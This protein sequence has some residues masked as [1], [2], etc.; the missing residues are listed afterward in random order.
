MFLKIWNWLKRNWKTVVGVIVAVGAAIGF[1]MRAFFMSEGETL[2]AI[3]KKI[4]LDAKR[5]REKAEQ[6]EGRLNE[7]IEKARADRA[8]LDRKRERANRRREEA[9][10]AIDDCDGDPDCIDRAVRDYARRPGDE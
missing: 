4:E 2:N 3:R 1:A 8:E 5:K 7:D 9:H 6:K 10:R